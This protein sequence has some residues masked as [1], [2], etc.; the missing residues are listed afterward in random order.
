VWKNLSRALDS[1]HPN[2]LPT[3]KPDSSQIQTETAVATKMPSSSTI[4]EISQN[5]SAAVHNSPLA[6]SSSSSYNSSSVATVTAAL[7]EWAV[8]CKALEEGR[9]VLLLRKGGIMEYREGFQ[10]KHNS[11]MLYPTFEHQLKESIQSDYAGKLDMIL[12]EQRAD[13]KITVTSYARA[14]A[15][16]QIDDSSLLS[17]LQKYHIWNEQYV[18]VRMNYNPRKPIQVVLLRVYKLENPIEAEVRPEWLGCKSWLHI[19]T[20]PSQLHSGYKHITFDERPVLDDLKFDKI[21]TEIE[22]I[23]TQ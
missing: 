22:E 2:H 11:F 12:Q 8:V 13:N 5:V 19:Q 3:D 15:V 17:K 7:K 21:A 20:F 23:L 4:P 9:Q 1:H 18:N 6:K 10:V 14:L 16:K